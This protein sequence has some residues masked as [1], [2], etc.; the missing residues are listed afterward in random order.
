M[1]RSRSASLPPGRRAAES[2]APHSLTPNGVRAISHA[3]YGGLSFVVGY[4]V[5]LAYWQSDRPNFGDDMNIWFWDRVIPGWREWRGDDS[6][7]FG[8]GTILNHTALSRGGR[9]LVLGSGTGYGGAE[10]ASHYPRVDFRFVRG[11]LTAKRMG[12]PMEQGANHGGILFV[13]HIA[14]DALPLPWSRWCEAM[15]VEYLSPTGDSEDVIRRISGA[16]MVLAESMHAA[17][18][19]DAYRVPW[20]AVQL[21]PGFNEFKWRDWASSLD[22]EFTSVHYAAAVARLV[23]GL[24]R[25]KDRPDGT[26]ASAPQSS[27][28]EAQP[29][30]ASEPGV[31]DVLGQSLKRFSVPV[32]LAFRGVLWQALRRRPSLSSDDVLNRRRQQLRD[33][34]DR[35]AELYGGGSEPGTWSQSHG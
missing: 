8:I 27:R 18:I 4:L 33:A 21:S 25:G 1:V 17:I 11:P 28:I 29:E 10:Q 13:P 3:G 22:V 5:R 26:R 14:T 20:V 15:G 12:L 31:Q 35:T 7:L 32:G 34:L 2:A 6:F 16:R 23:K 24:L 9:C 19:A 30:P